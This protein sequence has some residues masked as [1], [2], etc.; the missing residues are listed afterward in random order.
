[1][2]NK[3]LVLDL[4]YF[5]C[6]ELYDAHRS[7][8]PNS[9]EHSPAVKRI[10]AASVFEIA[11]DDEG[12]VTCGTLATWDEHA[13]GDE[14][15]IVRQLFTFLRAREDA[16]VLTYGGVPIDIPILQLAAMQYGVSVPPQLEDRPGRK[17]PRQHL[18]L[19]LLLKSSG[20]SW[21]HLSQVALRLDIP[22][23]LVAGKASVPRPSQAGAWRN[24]S[25][26]VE[27]DTLLLALAWTGW[28][29]SQGK[30]GLRYEPAAIALIAGFL[31][32]RPDHAMA[33]TL[34]AYSRSLAGRMEDALAAAA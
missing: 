17:G 3:Y 29:V 33:E 24:L 26:H 31:R 25:H 20:R 4:E 2:T 13:W 12:R 22:L 28:L 5:K 16:I 10:M 7:F 19:G 27:L 8:D 34:A 18:D 6:N 30:F 21:F 15:A 14:E 11:F 9:N 23:P 32:R 1:M